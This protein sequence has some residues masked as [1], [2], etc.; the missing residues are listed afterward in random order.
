MGPSW[1]DTF[2]TNDKVVVESYCKANDTTF[3]WNDDNGI[4]LIQKRSAIIQY[5]NMIIDHIS[6]I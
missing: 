2:E 4:R 1:Q 5:G 3:I 6:T